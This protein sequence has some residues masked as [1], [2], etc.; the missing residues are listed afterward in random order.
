LSWVNHILVIFITNLVQ[1]C[2]KS[3]THMIMKQN[4][5]NDVSEHRPFRSVYKRKKAISNN[6]ISIWFFQR[7]TNA[8]QTH[9]G[10]VA[11]VQR[12]TMALNA[13]AHRS[14]EEQLAMVRYWFRVRVRTFIQGLLVLGGSN[15]ISPLLFHVSQLRLSHRFI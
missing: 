1:T 14:I 15:S 12:S 13:H 11:L 2:T 9:A 5:N 8:N 4:V 6:M 10:T 7:E 3:K